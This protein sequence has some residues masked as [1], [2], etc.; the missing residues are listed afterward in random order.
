[1]KVRT[2]LIALTVVAAVDVSLSFGR[3]R[4]RSWAEKIA[5]ADAIV[6]GTVAE[7]ENK[8]YSLAVF[9][10]DSDGKQP[11]VTS[12][13]NLAVLHPETVLKAASDSM[14]NKANTSN[15]VAWMYMV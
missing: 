14:V 2:V 15:P 8:R 6:V 11:M 9:E 13:Y 10:R 12:F 7:I 4:S 1:M 5:Q 3:P